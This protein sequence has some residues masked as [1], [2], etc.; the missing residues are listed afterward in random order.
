MSSQ[1]CYDR[2]RYKFGRVDH[3]ND[4]KVADTSY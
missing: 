1:L 2:I 3:G 4:V